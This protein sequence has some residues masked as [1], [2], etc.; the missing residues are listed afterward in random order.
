MRQ[1]G[2]IFVKHRTDKE[3]N[4]YSDIYECLFHSKRY[5]VK[6]LLEIGIGTM[7]PGAYSSMVGYGLDGYKPGGSLRAWREYFPNAMIYGVDVQPDT[8]FSEHRICTMQASSVVQ[9]EVDRVF[10]EHFIQDLDIIV[11]DG[12]HAPIDQFTTLSIMFKYLKPG[13]TYVVEDI[14]GVDALTFME[15]AKKIVGEMPMFM[16]APWCSICVIAN[17][18]RGAYQS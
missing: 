1:L 16:L 18:L 4:C 15:E 3:R 13:G 2:P 10:K 6:R 14:G 5:E 12:S 11:D 7:I 9:E 17:P 8:Q